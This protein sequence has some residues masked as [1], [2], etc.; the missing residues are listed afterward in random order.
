[1][2]ETDRSDPAEL[3]ITWALFVKLQEAPMGELEDVWAFEEAAEEQIGVDGLMRGWDLVACYLL[4]R[5]REHAVHLGCDCGSD[6]WLRR[7]QIQVAEE[8]L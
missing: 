2:T 7:V 8:E 6:E 5:L 1:M 4:A 3:P